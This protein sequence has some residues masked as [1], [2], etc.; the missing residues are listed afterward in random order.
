MELAHRKGLLHHADDV[1]FVMTQML[2]AFKARTLAI[3]SRVS[4]SLI[5]KTDF[6]QIFDIMM[7]EIEVCLL[8]L[9]GYDRNK[10]AQENRE[11]LESKG[12]DFS[13]LNE[14]PAAA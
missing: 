12:V 13:A 10:F 11:H 14:P 8:E 9:S 7:R 1:E 6:K 4:R 3:P 2:T 5:G